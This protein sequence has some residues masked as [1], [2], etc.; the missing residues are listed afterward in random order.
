MYERMMLIGVSHKPE[1]LQPVTEFLE[2]IPLQGARVLKEF[3]NTDTTW[4]H[5]FYGP[6]CRF[7]IQNG[8]QLIHEEN[9]AHFTSL[10]DSEYRS[11]Y[12]EH[13]DLEWK[14]LEDQSEAA[15]IVN[16]RVTLERLASEFGQTLRRHADI[17]M[18]LNAKHRD[19]DILNIAMTQKPDIVIF[20][21]AHVNALLPIVQSIQGNENVEYV[22]FITQAAYALYDED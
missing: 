2:T 14:S 8:A 16:D 20:G 18:S 15:R 21:D 22:R 9:Y 12:K 6:L 1:M 7:L 19:P 3:D 5:E 4:M 11:C 10:S 13:H 17:L